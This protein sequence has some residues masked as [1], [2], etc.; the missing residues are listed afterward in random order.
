MCGIAGYVDTRGS[1]PELSL[2]E[3]MADLLAHRGPDSAQTRVLSSGASGP[4]AVFGHRRLKIIDLSD[5]AAQPLANEDG[6]IVVIYN[7]ELYNFR[8]LR[9]ELEAKGHIFSSHSDTE[10]IVRAYESFGDEFVSRLDGMFAFA[11]W[12]AR[13]RRLLLARDRMGK[14]PL[15]YAWD[16]HRLTFASEI[17]ALRAC[18]WV[19]QSV[20][21]KR[22]PELLAFGYVPWPRTLH[23]GILQVPPA[24][25]MTLEDGRLSEPRIYWA[26]RFAGDGGSGH[27]IE[28]SDAEELIRELLRAAVKRRL[29]SDVPLGVLLSGGID[30]SAI[31]ALMSELGVPVRTFT[32][33]VEDDASYD[34]RRFARLVAERFGTEHTE[35]VVRADAAALLDRLLWHLDQPLADSSAVPTY[36]IAGAAREHVTV[37]LTGDG[38]DEVFGGYERFAAALLADRLPRT[39]QHACGLAARFIPSTGGYHDIRR[40]LERFAADPDRPWEERYLSWVGLFGDE[41]LSR[42]LST[43]LIAEVSADDPRSSFHRALREAGD[44]PLLHQLLYANFRTYL[45]DDLLV[46]TDRMTMANSLEA[47]NPF[48]DTALVEEVALLPP[49]MKATAFGLKRLLRRSL[50]G[51]LPEKILRR[52]K[53]G[54]GV[55]VDK[56]FRGELREPFRDLVLATDA[57]TA[58]AINRAEVESLLGEHLDGRRNHGGRLWGLLALEAWLRLME[59][60]PEQRLSEPEIMRVEPAK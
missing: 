35:V 38:G 14:K 41:A 50:R 40:R 25:F 2:V 23:R 28:W 10:V 27:R 36:L 7:G 8:D 53:H 21:W 20:E 46:K 54:F 60:P 17:K 29:V 16:G 13:R 58:G 51:L 45:H 31:V 59:R 47:R 49:Q 9:R 5:A 30:S 3:Q 44:V 33:G 22:I 48:L 6:S 37:A 43:E 52:R 57:R 26:L 15:Y 12:D 11:L 34:E 18:P 24:S 39:L 42:L 1:A 19:D 32:V 56:W 55:P 4:T